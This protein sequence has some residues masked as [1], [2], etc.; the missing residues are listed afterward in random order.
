MKIGAPLISALLLTSATWAGAPS[1]DIA[2]PHAAGHAAV[3]HSHDEVSPTPSDSSADAAHAEAPAVNL[4]PREALSRLIDGN[5]RFRY[6]ES[7]FPRFDSARRSETFAVGQKPF[8]AVIGCADSRVPIEAIFDQGIG[9]LFVVRV[10]GNVAGTNEIGT[11]EYGVGHLGTGLI[12]VLGHT[13]CGAVTAVTEGAAVHGHIA[14]LVENIAPAVQ[15]VKQRDPE[16]R[17]ARLIRLSVR[18]NVQQSMADLLSKSETVATAV[19][20]G[21]AK[22]VGG[23][24]DLQTGAIEWLGEHPGQDAIL[25]GGVD[26]SAAHTTHSDPK[27]S[28]T[29]KPAP[30]QAEGASKHGGTVKPAQGHGPTTPTTQPHAAAKQKQ[31]NWLVLGGLLG[32]SAASSVATIHFVYN[33]R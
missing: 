7:R 26:A 25:A 31:D 13:K 12:V 17:G 28:P 3:S 20:S 6:G 29:K 30:H 23:V 22:V 2:P 1:H 19:K 24:Y 27:G 18:A 8:A 11:I 21:R 16:A 14:T 9:D 32:I 4:D 33:R 5:D 10:A 15:T